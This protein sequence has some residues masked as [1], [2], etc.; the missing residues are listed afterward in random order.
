MGVQ[1]RQI[2][3]IA[4]YGMVNPKL[5]KNQMPFKHGTLIIA[6]NAYHYRYYYYDCRKKIHTEM[7]LHIS[8]SHA[9]P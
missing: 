1:S 4:G 7:K 5:I 6:Y 3:F 8:Q 9:Y 2:T